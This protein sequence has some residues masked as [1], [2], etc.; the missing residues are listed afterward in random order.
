MFREEMENFLLRFLILMRSLFGKFNGN[1]GN[2]TL[3]SFYDGLENSH[4]SFYYTLGVLL[5]F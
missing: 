1:N 4:Y 5:D 2:F 3:Y